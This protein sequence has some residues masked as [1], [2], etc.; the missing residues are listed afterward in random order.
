MSQLSSP[1]AAWFGLVKCLIL[2]NSCLL[3][4]LILWCVTKEGEQSLLWSLS[5]IMLCHHPSCSSTRL[6]EKDSEG[7]DNRAGSAANNL[8]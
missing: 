4:M 8:P 1:R 3:W 2:C 7:E 6:G 5:Q